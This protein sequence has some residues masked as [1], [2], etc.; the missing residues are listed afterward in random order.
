[1]SPEGTLRFRRMTAAV[2]VLWAFSGLGLSLYGQWSSPRTVEPPIHTT[3]IGGFSVVSALGEE[4]RA[5]GVDYGDRVLEVDGQPIHTWYRERGWSRMSSGTPV[6]YRIR[7]ADGHIIEAALLPARIVSTYHRLLIPIFAT[8]ALV[9]FCY[10]L[11]GLFVWRLRSDRTESWTFLLFSSA[12]AT[13]LFTSVNSYD[14]PLGYE[15]VVIN[16][17]LVGATMFHLLTTFPTEPAWVARRPGLRMVPYLAVG[18]IVLA[19]LVER[20]SG[21]EFPNLPRLSYAVAMLGALAGLAVLVHE[22][23]QMR[24]AGVA[25][26]S[27]DLVLAGT[28]VSF[29]PVAV[30]TSA[31]LLF[32]VNWPYSFALLW[33]AAFPVAVGYG[34]VRGNLFDIRGAARSSAAYGAAT[35]AITGLFAAL[36]TFA[37]TLFR[38]FNVNSRSP[39]FSITFLFVAILAFNPLRDRLQTLVDRLF[40]RDRTGYRDALR[41]ISEAMVS[42]LSL[43]EISERLLTAVIETLDVERAMVLLIDENER[44][45]HPIAWRGHWD[46]DA[47]EFALSVDHPISRHLWMRRQ[48]LA[49]ANFDDFDDPEVREQCRDV[50]DA[51][52]ARLLV[53]ILFGVDLIG[54]I[55]VGAK[56][57]GEALVTDERELLRTLAN[58]SAIAIEN[59]K[60]FDEIATL[61]ATLEVRVDERTRELKE[62]QTQLMQS[63]KMRALGQ[64]VA[65]VAHELNNPI[66][67]VHANLQ[68]L[69]GYIEKLIKAQEQGEDAGKARDAIQKLLLRSREGTERV[70]RIVLDLRSFSRMDQ[71]GL[72]DADLNKEIERTLALMEP[73]F[74]GGVEVHT[75][76]GDLPLVRCYPAQL[77]QVFMNLV[78]NACD[79]MDGKGRIEVRTRRSAG[80]VTL[81]FCDDGP[82]IPGAVQEHIFEPFFTTKPVGQGTGLGLSISHQIVDR[83]GG[84]LS[85]DCPAAGG[86]QFRIELPLVADPD[87]TTEGA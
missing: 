57:S 40:D 69:D 15:R 77:N 65:G 62:T 51:L 23:I 56:L 17:P 46:E 64:L 79:A 52:E 72:S 68:L 27:A 3:T 31:Y 75:E 71:E 41:E 37:D 42:M 33:F 83:H 67:F 5:A 19:A 87:L 26:S 66:S 44:K 2:A 78:M 4:A 36:I 84:T 38:H 22:R 1:M 50:F 8:L 34:I 47:P 29:L 39:A 61:N 30:I 70:K 25:T 76:F 32:P 63:E 9:G 85:V 20:F 49:R 18:G 81:T 86:S 82:G 74:K 16:L 11:I 48:E 43:G 59:A 58:Q 54:V 53:P 60:A 12:M 28:L 7:A 13:A 24:G 6:Q 80:G 73:H 14:A 45:L 55:A 35:L 10:L 21:L